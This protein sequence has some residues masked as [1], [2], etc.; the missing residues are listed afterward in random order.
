MIRKNMFLILVISII[1]L[2]ACNENNI[3][4]F[5]SEDEAFKNFIKEENI[6]GN[7]DLLTTTNNEVLLV[8]QS[9]EIVY[10]IG[11]LIENHEGYYVKRLSDS[12]A[13]ELGGSWEFDTMGGNEYT[14][15]F[16]KNKEDM[17]YTQLSNGEFGILLVEGHVIGEDPLAFPNA[18]QQVEVIKD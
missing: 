11:E 13:L 14:I 18:V 4:Y 6:E 9:S 15:F 12:V 1:L 2:S 3:E 16:E 7:I 10:F 5:T 8:A 17:N